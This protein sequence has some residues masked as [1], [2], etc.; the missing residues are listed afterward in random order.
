MGGCL[1]G[2]PKILISPGNLTQTFCTPNKKFNSSGFINEFRE[3]SRLAFKIV[4]K[5]VPYTEGEQI[6]KEENHL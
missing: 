1:C 6:R 3:K 4:I 5:K 2:E